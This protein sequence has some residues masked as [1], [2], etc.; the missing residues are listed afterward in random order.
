MIGFIE[1]QVSNP[2]IHQPLL[3]SG[4]TKLTFL[5][6]LAA[7]CNGLQSCLQ[8]ELQRTVSLANPPTAT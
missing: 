1:L 8:I 2:H 7:A 5:C 6:A 4:L 3:P